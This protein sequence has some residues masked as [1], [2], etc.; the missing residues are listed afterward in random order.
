ML[1]AG[2]SVLKHLLDGT[3]FLKAL[4][5]YGAIEHDWENYDARN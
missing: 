3:R 5:R 4:S 2:H 1:D